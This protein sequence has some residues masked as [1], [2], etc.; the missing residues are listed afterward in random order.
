MDT[1]FLLS[2]YGVGILAAS[3]LGPIFVLTFNRAALHGFSR[4]LATA[5][6]SAAADMV[7]FSLALLGALTTVQESSSFMVAL[8]FVGGTTLLFLGLHM[9]HKANKAI[10]VSIGEKENILLTFTRSFFLTVVNPLTVLFFMLIIVKI[11]PEHGLPALT[12][13]LLVTS[14]LLLALGTVTVLGSVSLVASLLGHR[15]TPNALKII[16]YLT[17]LTFFGIGGYLLVRSL[18]T[19]FI[20]I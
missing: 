16:G 12:L 9:L 4:G 13:P 15:I 3:G 14:N 8:D 11:V 7:F 20:A 6:G 10:E 1:Q 18:Y 17:S 19:L 5:F 2:C